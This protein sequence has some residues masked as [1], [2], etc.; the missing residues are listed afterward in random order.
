M[1][2]GVFEDLMGFFLV[3]NIASVSLSFEYNFRKFVESAYAC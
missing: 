3:A 2:S 1:I